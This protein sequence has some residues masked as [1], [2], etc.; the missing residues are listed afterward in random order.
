MGSSSSSK[1]TIFSN[2]VNQEIRSLMHKRGMSQSALA[3]NTGISQSK[4]SKT[5]WH[6]EGSLTVDQLEVICNALGDD[7]SDLLRRA[8]RALATKLDQVAETAPTERFRRVPGSPY[9]VYEVEE[10]P[11]YDLAARRQRDTPEPSEEDYF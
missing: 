1:A 6:D 11:G 4:I 3:E 8:E 9:P 7:P 2:L 5:V 10:R